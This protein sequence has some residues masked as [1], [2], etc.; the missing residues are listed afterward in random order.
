LLE[1]L[2]DV[3]FVYYLGTAIILFPLK[4]APVRN[5][6]SADVYFK[7]V[8]LAISH[9]DICVLEN[10]QNLFPVK[11]VTQSIVDSEILTGS[12]ASFHSSIYER[13]SNLDLPCLLFVKFFP[14]DW[15]E[16]MKP[17]DSKSNN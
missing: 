17:E 11:K 15:N 8:W 10:I 4:G 13:T 12:G 5:F 2:G 3:I 16:N 1:K 9:L 14:E 6:K 7:R